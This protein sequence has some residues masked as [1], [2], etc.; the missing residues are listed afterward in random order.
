MSDTNGHIHSIVQQHYSEVATNS[1]SDTSKYYHSVASAFGYSE[2]E[3]EEL[4]GANLGLSCGNPIATSHLREGETVVDLGSGAGMDVI[5]AA[6]K[7]G[8]TGKAIGVEMTADMIKL[9][10]ENA[11]KRGL[12]N[13]EFIHSHIESL[14]LASSSVDCVISNCVLNL[15]PAES[16]LATL[17][18]VYRVL[19]PGGR[20]SISDIVAK[21]TLPESV[22][23]DAAA[24]VGCVAGAID[25]ATYESY[26]RDAGFK[27][28][29]YSSS[30]L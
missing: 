24:Y 20:I 16:K 21:Q 30:I 23:Q 4:R 26:L 5:L 7:V 28:E 2:E 10:R 17:K 12:T 25:T 29:I 15:V 14:P 27:G 8:P 13:A 19:K 11:T 1:A 6:H 3:I 18:E 9:A 22:A